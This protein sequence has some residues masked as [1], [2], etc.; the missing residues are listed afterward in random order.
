VGLWG[1][2]HEAANAKTTMKTT[3]PG[4]NDLSW[5]LLTSG[6]IMPFY[7]IRPVSNLNN[8]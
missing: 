2:L 4:T 6:S 7:R 5:L 1:A 3:M 8:F